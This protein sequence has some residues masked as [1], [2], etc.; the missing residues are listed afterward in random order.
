MAFSDLK[1]TYTAAVYPGD[2][3]EGGFWA[4]VLELPGCVAQAET[5]DDPQR[6]ILNAILAW[7][8]T[9]EEIDLEGPPRSVFTWS[10]SFDP[11]ELGADDLI[12]A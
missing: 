1:G 5:L 9:S 10:I 11:S 2:P 3:D 12:R 7:L 4:E 8:Q 6:N